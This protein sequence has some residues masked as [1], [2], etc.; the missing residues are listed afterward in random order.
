MIFALVED[1]LGSIIP[2]QGGVKPSLQVSKQTLVILAYNFKCIEHEF[3]LPNW[4]S[5]QRTCAKLLSIRR[6]A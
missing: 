2:F 4:T 5:A 1:F 3:S 6:A